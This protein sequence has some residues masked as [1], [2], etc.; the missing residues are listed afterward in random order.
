M[1]PNLCHPQH[2]PSDCRGV[3]V[4]LSGGR[5]FPVRWKVRPNREGFWSRRRVRTIARRLVSARVILLAS[6]ANDGGRA[7]A[8]Q[9]T[10][11]ALAVV[12]LH[13]AARAGADFGCRAR[14]Q[15][16]SGALADLRGKAPHRG[17]RLESRTGARY[18]GMAG[19]RIY[20]ARYLDR[21]GVHLQSVP[22]TTALITRLAC[23]GDDVQSAVRC[24]VERRSAC[25]GGRHQRLG[26]KSATALRAHSRLLPNVLPMSLRRAPFKRI[27]R[28]V[29]ISPAFFFRRSRTAAMRECR[30]SF[31]PARYDTPIARLAIWCTLWREMPRSRAIDA[32]VSPERSR[33][34]I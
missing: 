1:K 7:A 12:V 15:A 11:G 29:A 28:A 31:F 14:F 22:A 34:R 24:Q 26:C 30:T 8:A 5:T 13:R 20:S 10:A 18:C 17:P 19:E 32:N 9:S 21:G 27:S 16:L 6:G 3:L 23:I 2:R 4:S 33:A 25:M